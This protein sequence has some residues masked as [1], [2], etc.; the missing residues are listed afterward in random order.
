MLERQKNTVMNRLSKSMA[1]GEIGSVSWPG[2]GLAVPSSKSKA[3]PVA[4]KV[5]WGSDS[6]SAN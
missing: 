1:V 4:A 2:G 6:G 3:V 5:Y